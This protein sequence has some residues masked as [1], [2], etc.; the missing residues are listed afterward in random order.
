MTADAL[1]SPEQRGVHSGSF[2]VHNLV[3]SEI[4]KSISTDVVSITRP[5]AIDCHIYDRLI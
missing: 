3:N 4:N 1:P 5:I 2:T